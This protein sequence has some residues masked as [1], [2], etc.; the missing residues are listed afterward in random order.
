MP[1]AIS[2]LAQSQVLLLSPKMSQLLP[3]HLQT[4]GV[5]FKEVDYTSWEDAQQALQAHARRNGYAIIRKDI[6]PSKATA[7]RLVWQCEKSGKYKDRRDP[8]VHSNKQRKNTGTHKESCPFKVE[9]R[10]NP[11]QQTTWN[12]FVMEH[13][14][15]HDTL[16]SVTVH[17]SHRR[18]ILTSEDVT[19]I[20]NLASSLHSTTQILAVLRK[21]R[22]G[23]ALIPKDISNVIQAKRKEELGYL[24]PVEWLV[25]VHKL[26]QLLTNYLLTV[27]I[28]TR[29]WRLQLLLF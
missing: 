11:Y 17:P 18:A 5:P 19:H 27:L 29:S 24:S 7:K 22:P 9:A 1:S 4:L 26:K 25:K 10:K 14:H 23:I 3:Q 12:V 28:G 2:L 15:S 8:N 6:K 13:R 20:L 21:E 16:E